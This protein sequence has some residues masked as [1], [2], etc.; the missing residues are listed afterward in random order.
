MGDK[1]AV[2]KIIGWG[3]ACLGTI[4]LSYYTGWKLGEAIGE[5]IVG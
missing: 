3:A 5:Y 2:W 1:S 4:G